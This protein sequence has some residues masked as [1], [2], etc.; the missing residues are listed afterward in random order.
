M[1]VFSKRADLMIKQWMALEEKRLQ[2]LPAQKKL[3]ARKL[4]NRMTLNEPA[5]FRLPMPPSD[6]LYRRPL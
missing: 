3:E 2:E 4:K 1:T 6:E 5:N